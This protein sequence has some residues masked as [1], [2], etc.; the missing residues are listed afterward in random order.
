VD[1]GLTGADTPEEAIKLHE[2]LQGMFGRAELLLRKWNS[3]DPRVLCHIPSE[4]T[5]IWCIR[6]QIQ[7]NTPKH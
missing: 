1:D 6:F 7:M 3:N 5:L 2:E 4:L